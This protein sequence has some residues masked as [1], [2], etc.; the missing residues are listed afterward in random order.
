M[1]K[2]CPDCPETFK[3]GQALFH[4][5]RRDHGYIKQR[6]NKAHE[7]QLVAQGI[8]YA[9][10]QVDTIIHD[11]AARLGVPYAHVAGG[12]SG[13]IQRKAS[14]SVLGPQHSLPALRRKA[15]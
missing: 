14:G 5:R 4:H 13:F 15:S 6:E 7:E 2:Q 11:T 8:A 3:T 12:V 1:K 9:T 10:G